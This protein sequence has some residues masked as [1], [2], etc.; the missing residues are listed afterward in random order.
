MGALIGVGCFLVLTIICIFALSA[1]GYGTAFRRRR[2]EIGLLDKLD[3]GSFGGQ[4]Q[5]MREMISSLADRPYEEI[6]IK[7]H[8][9]LTLRCRYYHLR[10]GAP[11]QI[12][13]HG[14][15]SHPVRDFSGGGAMALASGYNL[16]LIY[17]RG[18]GRSEGRNITFGVL[19]CRDLHS[20]INYFIDR[21][22][23]DI[24]IALVG[25]SMG[26]ATVINAAA[27]PLPPSVKAV[28]ADCPY[29]SAREIISLVASRMGFPPRLIYPFIRLGAM[30]YGR[31][32]PDEISPISSARSVLVPMLLIH[33]EAD[34]FVPVEMSRA[35]YRSGREAG[36]NVTLL[37]FPDA[38]HGCSFL[39][40]EPRYRR[41]VADFLAKTVGSTAENAQDKR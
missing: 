26:A 18:H 30:L 38:D 33:G 41:E 39:T 34:G 23:P 40:D 11:L 13:C 12:Q 28:V 7:S 17:Q 5:R 14:Y 1:Y 20:W 6:E 9:G 32:D 29:S 16:A 25:I 8:D 19:E 10:D 22:G 4:G 37:T 36:R 2:R 35:I 21:Q 15:R 31:F 24:P 27:L 3:D